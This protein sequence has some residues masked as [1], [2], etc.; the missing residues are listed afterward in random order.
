M[1]AFALAPAVAA[2]C[3]WA[4]TLAATPTMARDRNSFFMGISFLDRHA[5]A[6]SSGAA[7]PVR[8]VVADRVG[9]GSQV[10]GCSIAIPYGKSSANQLR[11]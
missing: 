10:S 7:P 6:P 4:E 2:S 8:P 3:V 9:V 1:V 5:P 11:A